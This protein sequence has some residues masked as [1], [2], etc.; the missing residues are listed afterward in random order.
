MNEKD[1][2]ISF[3]N[4]YYGLRKSLE[5][6]FQSLD[7]VTTIQVLITRAKQQLFEKY[8]K[9]LISYHHSQNNE[10]LVQ[11]LQ[12]LF[13]PYEMILQDGNSSGTDKQ[14]SGEKQLDDMME[15]IPIASIYQKRE[16]QNKYTPLLANDNGSNNSRKP[17]H[18][19]L[20]EYASM[21]L[22]WLVWIPNYR[23]NL[24][25]L[26]RDIIAGLTVGAMVIPQGMA[27]ATIAG[28]LP[29]YGLYTALIPIFVYAFFGT[30]R[31]LAVGPT[32]VSALLLASSL[33][34][35]SAKL[36]PAS[37]AYITHALIFAILGGAIQLLM[38]VFRLGFLVNFLSHPVLSG[39]TSAAAVIIAASQIGNFIGVHLPK[40]NRIQYNVLNLM[41]NIEHIHF[42]TI[43]MGVSALMFLY[44]IDH[45]Y[46]K[47]RSDIKFTI[48]KKQ[49]TIPQK[50]TLKWLPS[51][52]ILV[53]LGIL[54][55]II[56]K[57]IGKYDTSAN[58]IFG[59]E[60]VGK[61][62]S[63]PP[64]PILPRL[65]EFWDFNYFQ[66]IIL[67]CFP[68]VVMGFM[69][70]ISTAKYYAAQNGY[71]IDANQE[72]IALGTA[73]LLGGFFRSFTS[74]GSLC[75]TSVNAS[76]GAKTPLAGIITGLV[77]L[78]T[79]SF[80][81]PLFY[82]LPMPVLAAIIIHS[83]TKIP[84]YDQVTFTFKTKKLDCALLA[85]AFFGTLFIGIMEGILIS[86]GASLVL[87]VLRSSR[88]QFSKLGRIPGT[89]AYQEVNRSTHGRELPGV[90]VMRFESDMY[91]AN[92]QYFKDIVKQYI[93]ES[94]YKVFAVV[95]DCSSINY[96][97]STGISTLQDL[98]QMLN[99][100]DVVLYIAQMKKTIQSSVNKTEIYTSDQFFVQL[101]EAV[102]HAESVV[103]TRVREMQITSKSGHDTISTYDVV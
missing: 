88:P 14:L 35:L 73:N 85:L 39:F 57:A 69:E 23:H 74:T 70:S 1:S 101:H 79:L 55:V 45:A 4:F 47:L 67:L 51:S 40:D 44:F 89:T 29:V 60:I 20:Y 87:V 54:S 17:V 15:T 16:N 83:T 9:E 24:S 84:D 48:F 22:P 3:S 96:I 91:F 52:L 82:H 41:K 19:L 64:Q 43:A 62:P 28:M 66:E 59:I 94:E 7:N 8:Y 53:I 38:G 77:V 68:V 31:Q 90:L 50:I 18:F 103:S 10:E 86:A 30:S 58:D 2:I 42:P 92:V 80:L 63:N 71:E 75:R 46:F 5:T 27:Y 49:I 102:L 95:L 56:I 98:H 12:Y 21:F 65:P 72:L 36:E 6:Q 93:K 11:Q 34:Q 26:G 61:V 100:L 76:A 32:A 81:T 99:K 37:P 97:D 78:L 13:N 33:N 25:D